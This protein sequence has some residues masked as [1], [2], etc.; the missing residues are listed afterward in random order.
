MV[1]LALL[2]GG[3]SG[4]TASGMTPM[5]LAMTTLGV[6]AACTAILVVIGLLIDRSAEHHDELG[7]KDR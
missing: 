1:A 5:A 4:L 6:V 3:S 2:Q 7:R